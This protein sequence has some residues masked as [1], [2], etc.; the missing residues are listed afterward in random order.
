MGP[1]GS[2]QA[3]AHCSLW[4][5]IVHVQLEVEGKITR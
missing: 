4:M 1:L 5:H 2:P 3:G